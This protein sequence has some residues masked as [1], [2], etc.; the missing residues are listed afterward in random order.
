MSANGFDS[1]ANRSGAPGHEDSAFGRL[2]L[3]IEEREYGTVSAHTTCFAYSIATWCFLT[4]GF[5]A[6][7]VGAVQ[8]VVCLLAGN[9]IGI[10]I[11]TMALGLG[12]QRYGIEQMDCCKPAF[13]QRGVKIPLLFYLINMLGWSGLLLVMFGNGI[14]NILGALGFEVGNWVV[15][16]GVVLGLALAYLVVTHGV[17]WLSISNSIITPGLGLLV[18][19]MF[20]K[21]ISDYGW[22]AIAAAPPIDPGPVPIT[23]YVIAIELGIANGISW[24]GGVGF[25]A[26]NTRTQRNAIYPEILQLGF[27]GSVACCIGLFSALVVQT[28]DPT[29]WMVP[30]GG[31]AMGILALTFVAL[32][33][34]T[35]TAVSIFASGLAMRHVRWFRATPWWQLMLLLAVP[36]L[37]FAFW[38]Q[39]LFNFGD[40]FL[41]YNG[42][43]YAPIS[44]ILFADYFFLRK[45]RI[46]LRALFE[47][48]P[49]GEYYFH[50]GFNWIA[51][52][53]LLLG[54]FLYIAIYNPASGETHPI[55]QFAP[56]SVVAT[57]VA[58]LSYGVGMRLFNR[59]E[60]AAA[61]AAGGKPRL[62]SPNI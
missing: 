29:R 36:C 41:A 21:L 26:R 59:R 3:L 47:S 7:L 32:A 42:T 56:A 46:N 6:E 9:M 4:G 40:A 45:Q 44:G 27:A 30:L 57:L 48:D 16:A 34:V 28:N 43:M 55:A 49:S 17:H 10:F 53:S 60:R 61:P 22:D 52:G 5:V 18:A 31:V 62:I 20:Y 51:L 8:G 2:P 50:R 39:E 1:E 12:C 37:P 11:T 35:S 15:G 54:Q 24:W 23:N 38:P 14:Y 33:N 19:F 25:L 58:A 13:G